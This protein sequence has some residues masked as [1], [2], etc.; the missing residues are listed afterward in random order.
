MTLRGRVEKGVVI[1]T[2]GGPLPEGTL[3]EVIP[4]EGAAGPAIPARGQLPPYPVSK[5]QKEALL[6]LIGMWKVEQ[7]PSDEE[8]ER[9]VEDYR[10]K[11]YG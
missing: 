6:G 4:V 7:P 1:L 3:V 10:M 8:V 2:S 11:K 9:I 5:E